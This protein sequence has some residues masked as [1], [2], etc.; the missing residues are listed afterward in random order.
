[1][2]IGSIT[3][4]NGKNGLIYVSDTEIF[5][6]N[7]WDITIAHDATE[8]AVFNDE[9]KSNF[10]GLKGWS[11][12]ITALH[13]QATKVLATAA[14]YDGTCAL[15]IY[16]DSTDQ[17]TY[18]SGSAIFGFGSSGD[19]SSAVGQTADFTGTGALTPTG[20]S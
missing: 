19:M 15:V 2:A 13:D 20:F 8:Y 12:S 16:P 18:Y 3:P 9:W 6:A 1:M 4:T 5:G 10:S 11:G 14:T 7:A 17:T